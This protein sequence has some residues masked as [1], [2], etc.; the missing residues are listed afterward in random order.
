[1]PDDIQAADA[2]ADAGQLAGL[3]AKSL[4]ALAAAGEADAACRIAGHACALYRGRDAAR[5]QQFNVL[6]HRLARRV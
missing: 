2:L 4:E 6:L 1:M 5:W 3:L